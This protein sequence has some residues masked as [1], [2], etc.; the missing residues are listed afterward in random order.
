MSDIRMKD[1][2]VEVRLTLDPEIYE[3]IV[4]YLSSD[5][6][7]EISMFVEEVVMSYIE[8]RSEL[9]EVDEE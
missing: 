6:L 3:S 9:K 7:L 5:D 1:G 8:M 2:M 4:E